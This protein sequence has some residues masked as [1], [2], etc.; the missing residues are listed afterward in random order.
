MSK[1]AILYIATNDYK[2]L[3][4]EFYTSCEKYFLPDQEKHYFIF[5]DD[6]SYFLDIPNSHIYIIEH[7]AWPYPTLKRFQYFLMAQDELGNM[8]YIYFFNSNMLFVDYIDNEILPEDLH[9]IVVVK[10]PWYFTLKD[11]KKFPY[12][13]QSESLAYIPYWLGDV[14]IMWWLNWWK[15]KEYLDMVKELDKN[16]KIDLKNNIIAKWHDESHI[17]NYILNKNNIKILWPE[18][19][20]LPKRYFYHPSIKPKLLIRDKIAYGI[21]SKYTLSQ[22]IKTYIDVFHLKVL[23]YLASF[24]K[25]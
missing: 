1:I 8:D 16:T 21:W 24:S 9:D 3:W 5:T 10:H 12:D 17:N 25:K 18:Y 15:S 23:K 19:W 2:I 7:E 20:S 6:A 22:K 4:N 13:R 14:Y 11:N